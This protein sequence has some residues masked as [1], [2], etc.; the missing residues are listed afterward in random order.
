MLTSVPQQVPSDLSQAFL[1]KEVGQSDWIG[2][3]SSLCY[4]SCP[5]VCFSIAVSVFAVSLCFLQLLRWLLPPF[6]LLSVSGVH[7]FC[8]FL[9]IYLLLCLI[10]TSKYLVYVNISQQISVVVLRCSTFK[11]ILLITSLLSGNVL[12]SICKSL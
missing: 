12:M 8:V 5:A 6:F 10:I 7:R 11:M 9:Y 2:C 3:W 1:D 4:C